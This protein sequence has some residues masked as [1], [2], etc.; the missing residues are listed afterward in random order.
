MSQRREGHI[1][2]QQRPKI[3]VTC[4]A[5]TPNE[6]PGESLSI[7]SISCWVCVIFF[8]RVVVSERL[9]RGAGG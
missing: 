4:L 7:W 6:T 8:A 5:Q 3:S 9:R 2:T 1:S